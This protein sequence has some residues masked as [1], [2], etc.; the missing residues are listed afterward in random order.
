MSLL[1]PLL[2]FCIGAVGV[3]LYQTFV[4]VRLLR[5]AGYSAG[6]KIAQLCL[7]WLLPLLGTYI[8]HAV[9]RTTEAR[10]KPRD[11]DFTPQGPQS[12]A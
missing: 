11:R 7:V 5:F 2:V 4:T 10:V 12:V 8:V 9:I 3:V 1:D 6:Q